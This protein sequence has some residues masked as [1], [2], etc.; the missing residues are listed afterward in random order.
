LA[1]GIGEEFRG[2]GIFAG[3]VGDGEGLVEVEIEEGAAA[4]L[5]LAGHDVVEARA[6]E[7]DEERIGD[8]AGGP[9]IGFVPPGDDGG[10][11]EVFSL[12]VEGD[13]IKGAVD[14]EVAGE[15]AFFG[16]VGEAGELEGEGLVAAGG[17]VDGA[18]EGFVFGTALDGVGVTAGREGDLGIAIADEMVAPEGEGGRMLG[19]GG[20]VEEMDAA[21]EGTRL[22]VGDVE[23][24][25]YGGVGVGEVGEKEEEERF[26][27]SFV[28]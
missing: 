9:G 23:V 21:G 2:G 5:I 27:D 26:H 7:A 11:V 28:P 3:G 17:Q 10:D 6:I 22:G 20:G 18:G 24:E 13:L 25:S 19:L 1:A 12:H 16:E 15:V 8:G 4:A 14:V